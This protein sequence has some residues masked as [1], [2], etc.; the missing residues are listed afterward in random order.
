ME[1]CYSSPS[2]LFFNG[3]FIHSE[4]GV[5]QG[6][7]IG[8]LLFA[9]AL[10]PVIVQLGNIPGLDLAFSYLD[11]LVLAGK[12]EAVAQGI[13]QLQDSAGPL[14]LRLNR[15]KCELIPASQNGNV[16]NWGLFDSDIQRNLNG[17]FK[18]LGA[19]IGK[20][21]YCQQITAKRADKIQRCLDAIG[22]LNDPQVALALLRSCV[23]FGKMM[24]ADRTMPFNNH[25][26]QLLFFENA[27][28]KCF[29]KFSG[30]CPDD[31]Q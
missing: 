6:D 7:P 22:E 3:I 25:Q 8:P 19:P 29:E 9:L 5:Q 4:V 30:L 21:E 26:D 16:I 20:A 11:D 23:L 1:W 15:S 12:Q 17:G 31:T 2:N 27:V 14:G 24:F 10:Q 18:L 13:N 28:Q